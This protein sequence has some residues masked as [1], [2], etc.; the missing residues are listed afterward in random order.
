MNLIVSIAS[1]KLEYN[2]RNYQDQGYEQTF[3]IGAECD[4]R[5]WGESSNGEESQVTVKKS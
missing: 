4:E 3:G 5:R 1:T 2:I